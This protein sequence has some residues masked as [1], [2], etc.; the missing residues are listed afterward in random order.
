M[1]ILPGFCA[2]NLLHFSPHDCQGNF[3]FSTD[4][5]RVT[6]GLPDGLTDESH[7]DGQKGNLL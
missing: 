3:L 2:G 5:G 7:D 6:D 1:M 4:S